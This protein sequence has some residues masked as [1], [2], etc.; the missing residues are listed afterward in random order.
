MV[1]EGV[2]HECLKHPKVTSVVVINRR[3]GEVRHPKLKEILHSNFHDMR[4]LEEDL[5]GFDAC[6]FCMGVSSL[7]RSAEEYQRTT[8]DLTLHV[9]TL[10]ARLNPNMTFC[11]VSG[12]GTDSSEKGRLRWARVKGRTENDLLKLPFKAAYMFRP[13]YIQPTPGLK[14]TYT[15]V[16][17]IA[18][19]YPLLKLVARNQVTTMEELGLAMIGAATSGYNKPVLECRDIVQLAGATVPSH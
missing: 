10:L 15:I 8:Y 5:T 2:L 13:G 14:H 4:P 1:G 6:L 9:A 17:F 18:P 19:F 12:A 3:P 16:K 7:G 11:Y